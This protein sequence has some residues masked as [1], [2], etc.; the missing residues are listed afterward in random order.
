MAT[1]QEKEELFQILK[2]TP[3]N[4]RIELTGYGG[5]I[6]MGTIDK[7]AYDY[8]IENE[9]DIS[10][11]AYDDANELDVK[12]EY[13]I[14]EPGCWYECDDLCH[15]N[16]VEMSG[17]S[18]VTV[19]NEHG[20][21]VFQNSLDIDNLEDKNIEVEEQEEIYVMDQPENTC[22]YM[23]QSIE[24]GLFFGGEFRL[25]SLFDPTKLKFYYGDYEGWVLCTNITYD[26][27]DILND[28]IETNGKDTHHVLLCAGKKNIE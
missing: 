28:D 11:Y 6:V 8:F 24:K 15:E 3:V 2:F 18:N 17:H 16:G 13:K 7:K 14:F 22:V 1:D 25:T 21:I 12:D 26:G 9:I 23:G 5:E 27:D 4:Y 10:E 20:D 19:Y